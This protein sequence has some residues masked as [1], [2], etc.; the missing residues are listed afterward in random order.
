[1]TLQFGVLKEDLIPRSTLGTVLVG[2]LCG[3]P[4]PVTSLCLKPQTVQNVFDNWFHSLYTE[5][6]YTAPSKAYSFRP[7]ELT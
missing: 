3:N 2:A 7:F 4:V 6:V 5:S 1:M